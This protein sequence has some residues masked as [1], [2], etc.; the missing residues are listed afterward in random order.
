MA[1][2]QKG[3]H[4]GR[5]CLNRERSSIDRPVMRRRIAGGLSFQP[6]ATFIGQK[7]EIARSRNFLARQ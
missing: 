3:T 1:A 5:P 2:C 7:P 6:V 4:E